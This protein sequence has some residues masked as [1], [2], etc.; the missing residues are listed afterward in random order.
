MT[1]SSPTLTIRPT[2][3]C[4][5]NAVEIATHY[6]TIFPS[7][8]I[9]KTVLYPSYGKEHHSYNKDDVMVIEFSLLNN[10]LYMAALNGPPNMFKFNEA[11][12]FTITPDGQEETDYYW[13]K[14]TEDADPTKQFCGWC[15][16]KFGLWWQVIPKQ[17]IAAMDPN[18]DDEKR[19]KAMEISMTWKKPDLAELER[20]LGK[21]DERN[22][23]SV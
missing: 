7:S 23:Q 13:T 14:L 12:S 9:T 17:C 4:G 1:P 16:D 3:F 18:E 20:E 19:S 8:T 10:S 11:I 21:I 15:Q 6:T 2:L 22:R 5:G